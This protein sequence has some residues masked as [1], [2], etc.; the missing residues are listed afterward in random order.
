MFQEA[1]FVSGDT[2]LTAWRLAMRDG[3]LVSS[4]CVLGCN[5]WIAMREIFIEGGKQ[6]RKRMLVQRHQWKSIMF[7]GRDGG[8]ETNNS[9]GRQA[10]REQPPIMK[11]ARS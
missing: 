7:S 4:L 8:L 11:L 5:G 6:P 3:I 2:H 9:Q 1:V 10:A